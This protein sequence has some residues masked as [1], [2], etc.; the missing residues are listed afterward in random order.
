[1]LP[2]ASWSHPVPRITEAE[3][4]DRLQRLRAAMAAA[5]VAGLLLG[6]TE[7]LRY[8][9]GFVWHASERFCGALV[10]RDRLVY[11]VPGFEVSRFETLPHLPGDCAPWQED[12]EPAALVADLV[13]PSG[14]LALD[15]QIPLFVYHRLAGA[16]G[17]DR[18]RDGG[19]LVSA[20][21]IR[22]SAAEIDLIRHAMGITLEVQ[23]RAFDAMR[24]GVRASE[25]VALIDAEH[26]R[27]GADGGST[28]A[29]VSFGAATALPHGAEGDQVLSA[30][31]LILVDTGCRLDGYHSDLTRTYMIDDPEPEIARIW[32]IER[33]A[34]EAV[35]AAARP[36]VAC[37]ALDEAARRV[38]AAHGLGPDYHL[39]GLP[40]R[41]GHGLGLEIHEAPYIVRGN[42]RVLE[43]GM[44]FSIE[45]MIV[46]PGRFGI[47]LEDHAHVTQS[48]ADWFTQPQASLT[49]LGV[50]RG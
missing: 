36:G 38:L 11:L 14:T 5:G 23:A 40:H 19:P 20:L 30:G 35:F 28:F 34:Q 45:P 46:L 6:A 25:I 49:D 33:E 26:R 43:P 18:L 44:C 1:M 50:T 3:R 27:M 16:M 22:K 24:P 17:T 7:S 8:F 15:E 37:S 41:A 29:I 47:R 9:T 32:A 4:L 10:T 31:D 2:F 12:E 21:R 48:G 39:P 42:G 13:G